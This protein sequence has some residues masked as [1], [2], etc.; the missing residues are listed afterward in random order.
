MKYFKNNKLKLFTAFSGIGSQEM[1]LKNL[2]LNFEVIGYSEIDK[3]AIKSY[4]LI[5]GEDI[6]NYGD[7]TKI[8]WRFIPDFDLLTYSSPCQ[9]FSNVG[10]RDGGD[11]DS[12]TKSSLIWNIEDC[13]KI[14][15]PKYLLLENVKNMVGYKFKPTFNRWCSLLNKYGYKNYWK[16]LNCKDFGIP[17]NRERVFLISIR[18]DVDLFVNFPSGFDNDKRLGHFL[19]ND[20][21]K[22]YFLKTDELEYLI[23]NAIKRKDEINIRNIDEYFSNISFFKL[24]DN[25]VVDKYNLKCMLEK[26][27]KRFGNHYCIDTDIHPTLCAIGKSDV[28]FYIDDNLVIRKL[29]E[30]ECWKLMGFSISDYDKI[31]DKISMSQIYKQIGN[32]ICVNVLEFVFYELLKYD[33]DIKRNP[34]NFYND[35]I[36]NNNLNNYFN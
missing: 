6:K 12:G 27:K 21:D 32:S 1:A 14:K 36:K 16:V 24:S 18:N 20:I 17:Q 31:K 10:K 19:E 22:K 25:Y 28:A 8:D 5:H 2:G 30:K 7:I 26:S 9:S 11:R 4:K 23:K 33:Y 3:Y 35:K 15:K 13:I 29:T 34:Y